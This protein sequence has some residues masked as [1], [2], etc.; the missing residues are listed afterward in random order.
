MLEKSKSTEVTAQTLIAENIIKKEK[1]GI[2]ILATG[3]LTKKLTVKASKF[4][5]KAKEQ[6]EAAGGKAEVI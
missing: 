6:I 2:V 5:A 1:D 3:K 4:T